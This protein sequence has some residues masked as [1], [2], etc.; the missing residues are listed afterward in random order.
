MTRY[1]I[2]A[3]TCPV[4]GTSIELSS[5]VV[6]V[7]CPECETAL[8]LRD[9]LCPNCG[10]YHSQ[11]PSSCSTCGLGMTALCPQ[12]GARNWTGDTVCQA[13]STT[14]DLIG[15]LTAQADTSQRLQDQMTRARAIKAKEEA[16]SNARLARMLEEEQAEREALRR[17]L[18]AQKAQERNLLTMISVA[19]GI[20][21]LIVIVYALILLL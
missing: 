17:R 12:C 3:M 1:L 15:R 4:C 9:R 21:L 20:L 6:D 7:T 8:H 18:E 5:D 13:C 2:P 19:M 11:P 14:L 16:A 10:T